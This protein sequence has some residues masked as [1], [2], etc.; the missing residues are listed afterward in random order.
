MF[1]H[2]YELEV[3]GNEPKSFQSV[4]YN[5]QTLPETV[6]L[7]LWCPC[8][9]STVNWYQLASRLGVRHCVY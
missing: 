3:E 8:S 6:I 5:L 1:L 9:P 4:Q 7:T 2:I